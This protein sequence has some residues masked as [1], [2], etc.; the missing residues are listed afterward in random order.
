METGPVPVR[1]EDGLSV[2]ASILA[3]MLALS[4]GFQAVLLFG[5]AMYL[6]AF[7]VLRRWNIADETE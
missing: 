5:A 2:L 6:P 1:T 7:W 3:I 4:A